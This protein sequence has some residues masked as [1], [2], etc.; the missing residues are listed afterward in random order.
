MASVF[1]IGQPARDVERLTRGIRDPRKRTISHIRRAGRRLSCSATRN[2]VALKIARAEMRDLRQLLYRSGVSIEDVASATPA[3]LRCLVQR[4]VIFNNIFSALWAIGPMLL[5]YG[6]F[7]W[8]LFYED[9]P[10]PIDIVFV[11]WYGLLTSVTYKVWSKTND[12]FRRMLKFSTGHRQFTLKYAWLIILFLFLGTSA[13]FFYFVPRVTSRINFHSVT[14]ASAQGLLF[15]MYIFL[16]YRAIRMIIRWRFPELALVRAL[17]DAFEMVAGG[18]PANWRRISLRSKVAH[19]INQAAHTLEGP[20][21]RKF[22]A[23]AGPAVAAAIDERFLMAGAALRSKV[24]WLATPRVDTQKF[25]SGALAEELLIAATGDLDRLDYVEIGGTGLKTA[26]LFA[27][28]RATTSWAVFGFGPAIFVVVGK[29]V[30]LISD[31]GTIAILIQFAA[32]SFFV[33]VLAVADPAGYKDRLSSV[34]GAGA[35]LF[36]WRT[37]GKKE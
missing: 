10:L 36:G 21:A 27:R 4:Q 26:G 14:I 16:V 5:L 34:T 8:G 20:I 3:L 23:S 12:D 28:L 17:A 31:P 1:D 11:M 15:L 19:C 22:S 24:A 7:M 32:L 13:S 29:T 37:T 30:G 33:A 25:L 35:A 6:T 9:D 18:N 2:R